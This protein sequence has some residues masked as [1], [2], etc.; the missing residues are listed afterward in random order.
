MA[1]NLDDLLAIRTRF[2]E[3]WTAAHPT[4]PFIFDN[5]P[6]TDQPEGIW[7]RLSIA[8]GHSKTRPLN[9]P[10]YVQYG[11]VYLQVFVPEGEADAEGYR[12]A[13][14]FAQA[15]RNWRNTSPRIYCEQPEFRPSQSDGE[16]FM[17]LVTV[18]YSSE[19]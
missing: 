2:V 9:P 16:S 14:T 15:F 4:V 5:E 18:P 13:E 6:A 11:R 8:P 17:I 7:A 1:T 10:R 12:I 19:H 3:T